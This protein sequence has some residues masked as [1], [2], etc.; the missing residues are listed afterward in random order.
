MTK[1][2]LVAR[3]HART[4]SPLGLMFTTSALD[5]LIKDGLVPAGHRDGNDGRKPRYRFS[6]RHLHRVTFL[7]ALQ[8]RG[9][10]RRDA[11]RLRLFVAGCRLPLWE[12]RQALIS[13]YRAAAA[14]L[15]SQTRSAYLDNQRPL[16]PAKVAAIAREIGPA[17]KILRDAG[18]EPPVEL[19]IPILRAARQEP[20]SEDLGTLP[21]DL[22][23]KLATG[24]ATPSDLTAI[25]DR[26]F[27]GMFLMGAD[28]GDDPGALDSVEALIAHADER[29]LALVPTL[30]RA[31]V[32]H[33]ANTG[34]FG[35]PPDGGPEGVRSVV[36]RTIKR[37]PPFLAFHLVMALRMAVTMPAD[38]SAEHM[39]FA[40]W[41]MKDPN[42]I[43][44]IQSA[45]NSEAQGAIFQR[46]SAE[47]KAAGDSR[48]QE[49]K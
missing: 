16:T 37:S 44:A 34:M 22:F 46:Y 17:D 25:A 19:T 4:A 27:A 38:L 18:L 36:V 7:V 1:A 6:W 39:E 5:D 28:P 48:P 2:E 29:A 40:H 42:R 26:A 33:L 24:S 14:S 31:M 47:F 23:G 35:L 3:V 49:F 12:V 21:T 9:V 43:L 45:S 32:R 15:N 20:L 10:R 13:E 41:L 8:A 11:Q 30:F